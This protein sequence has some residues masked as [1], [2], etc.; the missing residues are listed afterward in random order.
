MLV[1]HSS[2][3]SAVSKNVSGD[4][5]F[6]LSNGLGGFLSL[7]IPSRY[8]GLHF[9]LDG[10][11]FKILDDVCLNGA[12]QSIHNEFSRITRQKE[13]AR[14]L[15]FLPATNA[16]I[17]S[18]DSFQTI[19]LHLDVKKPYDN[20]NWGRNYAFSREKGI[21]FV[22]F[23]KQTD[24]REDPTNGEVEYSIHIAI[25]VIGRPC[26]FQGRWIK[27]KY[28]FDIE[29]NSGPFERYVFA[30]E[31]FDCKGFILAAGKTKEECISLCKQ[32]RTHVHLD[33]SAI[34]VKQDENLLP[35][36]LR[37]A[38]DALSKLLVRSDAPRLYAGL[39]WFF[40][41]WQRD[42]FISLKA[43]MLQKQYQLVKEFFISSLANF[44]GGML[45][46]IVPPSAI[47]SAD[48]TGWYFFRFGEFLD[49]LR[50][51]GKL[52]DFFTIS[53]IDSLVGCLKSSF[54]AITEK[55]LAGGLVHNLAQ[56]TWMDS[57]FG[58]DTR[59]GARIEIQVLFASLTGLLYRLTDDA[60]YLHYQ[61]E[62]VARLKNTFFY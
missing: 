37:C 36:A 62:F 20:R 33:F 32:L 42:T 55:H 24:I 44:R 29:R 2:G 30:S 49:M 43:L 41:P 38:S 58:G 50:K 10:E 48:A 14:E 21:S 5:G 15:F 35:I 19:E 23:T 17:Y 46:N 40:Q 27:K 47:G 61:Q 4:R 51:E 3:G 39:P 6:L 34:P 57:G 22:T 54:S 12:V 7:G 45:P 56:E 11:I 13:N 53:E 8:S 31:P 59:P 16:M 52:F 28:A 1:V 26:K 25:S 9:A 18:L 60:M